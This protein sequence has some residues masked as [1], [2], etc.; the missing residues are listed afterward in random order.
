M[1]YFRQL[2]R[3]AG[4]ATFQR[5]FAACDSERGSHSGFSCLV[6][7]HADSS[8]GIVLLANEIDTDA[9]DRLPLLANGMGMA[10]DAEVLP[11]PCPEFSRSSWPLRTYRTT[12]LGEGYRTIAV[13]IVEF[14]IME[15]FTSRCDRLRWVGT[16]WLRSRSLALQVA[17]LQLCCHR[18]SRFQLFQSPSKSIA[19]V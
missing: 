13:C 5:V 9:M 10:L 14:C 4:L 12:R 19:T 15:R 8:I 2:F 17:L 7:L 16:R 3:L 11:V 6:V 1:Q 18:Q